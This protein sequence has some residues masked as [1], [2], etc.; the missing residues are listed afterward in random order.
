[1]ACTPATVVQLVLRGRG[2]TIA[3]RTATCDGRRV[4]RLRP[5]KGAV[6]ALRRAGGP[7]RATLRVRAPGAPAVT[8]RVTLR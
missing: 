1:M 4:L 8:G 6:Q 5:R 2:R 3:R 7:V